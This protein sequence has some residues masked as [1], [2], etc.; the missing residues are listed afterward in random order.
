MKVPRNERSRQRKFPGTFVSQERKFPRTKSLGNKSSLLG[1]KVPHRDYSFLGTKGLGHKKS[2]YPQYNMLPAQNGDR[3][4]SL[5]PMHKT[6]T[7]SNDRERQQKTKKTPI[8]LSIERGKRRMLTAVH[9]VARLQSITRVSPT[10]PASPNVF[11]AFRSF[12][13]ICI[14]LSLQSARCFSPSASSQ[15]FTAC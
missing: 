10:S 9:G 5:H 4:L 6:L 13:S 14:A 8:R 2:R 1:T 11:S 15:L 3:V 12:L 7:G